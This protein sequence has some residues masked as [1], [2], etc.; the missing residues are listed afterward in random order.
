VTPRAAAISPPA[1]VAPTRIPLFAWLGSL[2]LALGFLFGT[3]QARIERINYVSGLSDWSGG[4]SPL[5]GLPAREGGW[6]PRLII[7]EHSNSSYEWLD[8]TL[9]MFARGEWRVRHVDYENAPFGRE[10]YAASPYRWWLGLLAWLDHAALGHPLGE[11]LERAA[12]VADPLL[13]C[14]FILGTGAFAARQFGAYSAAFLSLGMAAYFPFA[15]QFLP[16]EPDDLGFAGILGIWSLLTLV[17]GLR[18]LLSGAPD[19][20]ARA[21]RWF[22]AAGVVGGAGL[23]ANVGKEIPVLAGLALGGLAAAWV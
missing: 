16:G 15:A 19:A 14:L 2:I 23:W 10:V 1:P 13:L 20:A 18:A 8:Q 7:P 12:L 5:S 11:S 9:Q 21:R 6:A 17:V 4:G 3:T 22:C